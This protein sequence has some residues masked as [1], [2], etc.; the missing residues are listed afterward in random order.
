MP[1]ST[2]RELA[3]EGIEKCKQATELAVPLKNHPDPQVRE[4]AKAIHFL[5]YG[6]QQIGLAIT[7]EGRIDDLPTE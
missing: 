1:M 4:L 2:R 5:A 7:D 6:A 3:L